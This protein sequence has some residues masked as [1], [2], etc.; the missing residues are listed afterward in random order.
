[1][2]EEMIPGEKYAQTQYVKYILNR[3]AITDDSDVPAKVPFL[4]SEKFDDH[5]SI[6]GVSGMEILNK[7]P[8][9]SLEEE[10]EQ[11]KNKKFEIVLVALTGDVDMIFTTVR[12]EGDP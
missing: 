1:M 12:P 6:D 10:L 2:Q 11:A 4:Q 5:I 9:M 8:R 7:T 3:I